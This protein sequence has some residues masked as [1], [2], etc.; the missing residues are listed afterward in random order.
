MNKFVNIRVKTDCKTAKSRMDHISF[1]RDKVIREKGRSLKTEY[2]IENPINTSND[3][4]RK[5]LN[6]T[7]YY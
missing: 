5:Y 3:F 6:A 1:S 7:Y 4:T 2:D